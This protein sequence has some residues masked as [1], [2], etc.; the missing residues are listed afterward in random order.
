MD[1]KVGGQE[2]PRAPGPRV[3][4]PPPAPGVLPL[5][6]KGPGW[7]VEGFSTSFEHGQSSVVSSLQNVALLPEGPEN[8]Q[9]SLLFLVFN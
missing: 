3:T 1:G 4:W 8:K 9:R 6:S 5:E 2:D 7:G